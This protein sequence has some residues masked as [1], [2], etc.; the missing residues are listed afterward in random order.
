MF[1]ALACGIDGAKLA[2]GLAA[3]LQLD[4][5]SAVGIVNYSCGSIELVIDRADE[6]AFEHN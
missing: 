3:Q 5:A 6:S 1:L 2:Q 4:E